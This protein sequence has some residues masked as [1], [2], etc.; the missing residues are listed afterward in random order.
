ME[1]GYYL[2]WEA[3]IRKEHGLALTK[4]HKQA[5]AGLFNFD[6]DED[7]ER[8]LYIDELPRSN[9]PWYE[10][11]R[12]IASHLVVKQ[13][14]TFDSHYEV[15]CGGWPELVE[16]LQEHGN[17]LS[18]PED[19]NSPIDVVPKEIQHQLWLQYCFDALSGLGQ[20]GIRG[21]EN[22]DTHFRIKM[23]IDRLRECKASI[24]FQDLTLEKLLTTLIL[25]PKD[26]KIFVDLMLKKLRMNS[27]KDRLAE[28]S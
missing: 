17:D 4:S 8:I 18:I 5:L 9:L 19:A 22:S 26:A 27:V 25:P 7:D 14:K 3:V 16:C 23:F 15:T 20:P 11:A 10:I 6:D 21:L 1:R 28:F 24:Q 13:F 12:K 2:Q